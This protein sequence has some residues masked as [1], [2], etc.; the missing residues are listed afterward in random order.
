MIVVALLG[1]VLGLAAMGAGWWLDLADRRARP[2]PLLDALRKPAAARDFSMMLRGGGP[3]LVLPPV[4]LVV[5]WI[6]DLA[7]PPELVE[8][9]FYAVLA[10]A[11]L[12]LVS[13]VVLAFRW[14]PRPGMPGRR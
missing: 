6:L 11:A 3:M 10:F 8:V 14:W 4:P 2:F 1:L 5:F 12:I 13:T 7:V 9:V